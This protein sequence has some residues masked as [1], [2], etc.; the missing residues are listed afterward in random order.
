MMNTVSK[1]TLIASLVIFGWLTSLSTFA[2][3]FNF[4]L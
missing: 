3:R 4:N 2:S 1:K